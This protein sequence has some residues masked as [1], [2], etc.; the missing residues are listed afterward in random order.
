MTTGHLFR[1]SWRRQPSRAR[2]FEDAAFDIEG[3]SPAVVSV[4]GRPLYMVDHQHVH[5]SLGRHQS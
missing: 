2:E 4:F 3:K 5:G 1:P